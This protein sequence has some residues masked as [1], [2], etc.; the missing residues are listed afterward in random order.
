[1]PRVRAQDDHHPH[2]AERREDL[3]ARLPLELRHL[4]GTTI[5][6]RP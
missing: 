4:C 5:L 1:M 6:Q 2:Q 3:P